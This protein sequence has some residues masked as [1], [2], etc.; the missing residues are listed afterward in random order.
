MFLL[1]RAN[2]EDIENTVAVM[3]GEDWSMWIDAL[4][5]ENLLADGAT[6]LLILI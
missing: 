1:N 6:Q 2:G 5:A 4:K 3:G